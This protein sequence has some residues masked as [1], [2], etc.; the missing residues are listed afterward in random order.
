MPAAL[1]EVRAGAAGAR[2]RLESGGSAHRG[3]GSAAHH[4]GPGREAAPGAPRCRRRARGAGGGSCRSAEVNKRQ[5]TE[6]SAHGAVGKG[7]REPRA[8]GPGHERGERPPPGR[9]LG[10]R[11]AGGSPGNWLGEGIGSSCPGAAGT[12]VKFGAIRWPD[13]SQVPL[14]GSCPPCS[15]S[16][17]P[18]WKAEAK[19]CEWSEWE[20]V[21]R[22]EL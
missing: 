21:L 17:N 5:V 20:R 2:S 4:G 12:A 13:F 15:E 11:R 22:G 10:R 18:A 6:D 3:V 19:K 7:W 8:A 14:L 16:G 1:G 9:A